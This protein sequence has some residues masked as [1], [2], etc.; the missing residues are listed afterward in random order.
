[1]RHF[2]TAAGEDEPGGSN[3]PGYIQDFI[4]KSLSRISNRVV[5]Q[6]TYLHLIKFE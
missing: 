3:F 6:R 5:L 1:M 4:R 2:V